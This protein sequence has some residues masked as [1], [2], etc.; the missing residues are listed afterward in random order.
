MSINR[1]ITQ[2]L[3]EILEPFQ[4]MDLYK[5]VKKDLPDVYFQLIRGVDK[6][7]FDH[8]DRR[9]Q[10]MLLELDPLVDHRKYHWQMIPLR[11]KAPFTSDWPNATFNHDELVRRH[12]RGENLGLILGERSEWVVD[13]D[14]D[15]PEAMAATALL[16]RSNTRFGRDEEKSTHYLY[17]SEDVCTV[18]FVDPVRVTNKEKDTMM[19]ELRSTGCQT[20]IPPSVHP[21]TQKPLQWHEMGDLVEVSQEELEQAVGKVAAA[22]LLARYWP[23]EGNRHF[24]SMHLT[25]ALAHAGWEQEAIEEFVRVVV[26][27]AGDEEV[28]G[29]LANARTAVEN[30]QAGRPVTGWPSLTQALPHGDLIVPR[31]M[32]WLG[33]NRNQVL[34]EDVELEDEDVEVAEDLGVRTESLRRCGREVREK[35]RSITWQRL[36]HCRTEPFGLVLV[37]WVADDDEMTV[38][39]LRTFREC[40]LASN[41]ILAEQSAG[42]GHVSDERVREA[43]ADFSRRSELRIEFHPRLQMRYRICRQADLE[44]LHVL[45]DASHSNRCVSARLLEIGLG[46]T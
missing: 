21:D 2:P 33:I 17:R 8:Q 35:W 20:M 4:R 3:N 18:K 7:R 46:L 32:E 6:A 37:R 13:V 27:I 43:Y 45:D 14:L 11:G 23:S 31:V 42:R 30:L 16:P 39:T 1:V 40:A 10:Q 36:L 25:G 9:L 19:V 38:V 24:T 29:R 26:T 5:E 22:S 28:R 41:G 34:S 15:C 44:G 12:A